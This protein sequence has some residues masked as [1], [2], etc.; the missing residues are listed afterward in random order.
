MN[1]EALLGPLPTHYESIHRVESTRGA[2]F[3]AFVNRQTG[4][5][6]V[7]DPRLG[8]LPENWR[9][10]FH[11]EENFWH[12]FYNSKT[13]EGQEYPT[14]LDPRLTYQALIERGVDLIDIELV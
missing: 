8:H 4:Q 6:Q 12:W 3:A 14:A 2:T 7:Q 1:G 11:E 10:R 5:T 9:L 13:R